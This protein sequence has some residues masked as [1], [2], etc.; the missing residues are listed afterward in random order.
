MWKRYPGIIKSY[1]LQVLQ[2]LARVLSRKLSLLNFRKSP[3]LLIA[4]NSQNMF[5]RTKAV[6][7]IR[8][9]SIENLLTLLHRRWLQ[10]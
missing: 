5:H 3:F 4:K 9:R 2:H 7:M 10:S 1:T 8:L 6:S